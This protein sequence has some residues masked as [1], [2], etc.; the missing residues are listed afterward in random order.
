MQEI[1]L[2]IQHN[3]ALSL[4]LIVVLILLII[5][6]LIRAKR[7][8]IRISPMAAT[9][10]INHQ[11]GVVVDIRSNDAFA[12]GH[13][14][15]ALS[16]PLSELDTQYKKLEKFI[17]R[18]IVIACATGLESPRAADVLIKHGFSV[19]ILA[20]GIRGWKEVDMPLVKR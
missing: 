14:V 1:V 16:I 10:M 2:F 12:S 9:Q 8:A 19:H 4:A 11:D 17:S 7:G 5:L 18:P 6:E 15:D 13:I 3:L 20:G